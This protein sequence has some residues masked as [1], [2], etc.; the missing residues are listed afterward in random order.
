[1]HWRNLG[2]PSNI[3][4][5]PAKRGRKNSNNIFKSFDNEKN[6]NSSNDGNETTQIQSNGNNMVNIPNV[7]QPRPQSARNS[8]ESQEIAQNGEMNNN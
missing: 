4:P 2:D 7:G 1:M 8:A 6:Q 3:P 5:S